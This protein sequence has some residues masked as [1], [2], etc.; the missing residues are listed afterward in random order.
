MLLALLC[1]IT[2]PCLLDPL[3]DR[4]PVYM[5]FWLWFYS[6]LLM[7]WL[8]R[9]NLVNPFCE[10]VEEYEAEEQDDRGRLRDE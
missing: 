7:E 5:S 1:E 8:W 6:S 2:V 3:L 4:D 10:A 9:R